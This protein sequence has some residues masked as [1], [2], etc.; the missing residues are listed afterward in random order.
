MQ[1]AYNIYC[2]NAYITKPSSAS[3]KNCKQMHFDIWRLGGSSISIL[4]ELG[5]TP[6]D[7]GYTFRAQ[8]ISPPW[9]FAPPPPPS[10]KFQWGGGWWSR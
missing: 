8:N 2:I 6:V 10:T 1:K 3:R 9:S 7:S 4:V 5:L